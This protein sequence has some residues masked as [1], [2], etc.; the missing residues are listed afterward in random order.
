PRDSE[1]PPDPSPGWG[2][3]SVSFVGYGSAGPQRAQHLVTQAVRCRTAAAGADQVLDLLGQVVGVQAL[4]A[5]VQVRADVVAV[6]VGQLVVQEGVELLQRP[7][8]VV[9]ARCALGH[10][11]GSSVAVEPGVGRPDASRGR[12]WWRSPASRITP[13]SRAWSANMPR[14]RERP[15]FSRD[16]TVP[17]GV[18]MISAISL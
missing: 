12:W 6:G 3:S 16:I 8:T 15:R 17:I 11:R 5:Q 18:P 7:L 9:L 1:A 4:L 2:R 14:S 13:I 10:G